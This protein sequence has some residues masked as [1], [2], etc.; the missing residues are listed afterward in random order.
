MGKSQAADRQTLDQ[1]NTVYHK[2]HTV[3]M[4]TFHILLGICFVEIYFFRKFRSNVLKYHNM[5]ASL[6]ST[7]NR[8]GQ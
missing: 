5:K 2:G 8:S 3:C 7:I 4:N 1:N 6:I